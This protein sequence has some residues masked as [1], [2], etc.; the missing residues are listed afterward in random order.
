MTASAPRKCWRYWFRSGLVRSATTRPG[1]FWPP[2]VVAL[3]SIG[4]TSQ[5]S[6]SSLNMRWPTYPAAP[7]IT[8]R[9]FAMGILPF[10]PALWHPFAPAA[11]ITIERWDHSSD[12]DHDRAARGARLAAPRRGPRRARLR[13]REG[14]DRAGSGRGARR[15]LRRGRRVPLPHRDGAARLR[16]RRVQVLRLSAAAGGG[17]AP[18]GAVLAARVHREPL[19][20][21]P[22]HRRALPRHARRVP[23]P[24]PSRRP[25]QA[26]AARPALRRGRLQ[27]PAPGRVRRAPVSDPGHGAPGRAR[28]RLHGRRIRAGRAAAAH[29]VARRGR[30]AR[31]GRLRRLSRA[32]SPGAGRARELSRDNAP[33][34]EP[35]ALGP[36][37]HPRH[38][39]SRRAMTMHD[40][41]CRSREARP[42]AGPSGPPAICSPA[43]RR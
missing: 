13:C 24:L 30:A 3:T 17:R 25:N 22:G 11:R 26:D 2:L 34:R 6:A 9:L 4:T 19:E 43:P 39:L 29:A 18:R 7:V 35:A 32:T 42:K 27:L 23:R 8:T 38:H 41:R 20:R 28:P 31:A 33:R 14:P 37:P 15:E 1:T 10:R 36:P 5:R 12:D 16:A 40:A 21:G